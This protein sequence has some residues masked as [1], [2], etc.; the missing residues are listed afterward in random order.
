M[1]DFFHYSLS[2]IHYSLLLHYSRPEQV[3][4]IQCT[5]QAV[6][7]VGN[8]SAI[9][10]V[11][12][13]QFEY[14]SRKIMC[15]YGF[16][17]PGHYLVD[18][19]LLQVYVLVQCSAQVAISVNAQ[20]PVVIINNRGHAHAFAAHLQQSFGY[21]CAGCNTWYIVTGMHDVRDVQQQAA[22]QAAAGVRE[23]KIFLSKATCLQQGNCQCIAH[24]QGNGCA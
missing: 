22:A 13:H 8:K 2:V 6:V 4:H 1:R 15:I 21:R 19:C 17:I 3:V 9:D 24:D 14:F 12:F 18:S 20:H 5:E 16:S 11:V 10:L 7:A 23:C